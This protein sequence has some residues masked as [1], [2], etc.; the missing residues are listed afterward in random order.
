MLEGAGGVVGRLTTEVLKYSAEMQHRVFVHPSNQKNL[1]L[2]KQSI[3][4]N[5][6][7]LCDKLHVALELRLIESVLTG[8]CD[9]ETLLEAPPAVEKVA[10]SASSD[11]TV[12][13][14]E[15]DAEMDTAVSDRGRKTVQGGGASQKLTSLS[16][17]KSANDTPN[18]TETA[19]PQNSRERV[20][21]ECRPKA[22]SP[23]ILN[24]FRP[25]HEVSGN[26]SVVNSILTSVQKE[27]TAKESLQSGQGSVRGMKRQRREDFQGPSIG[28]EGV[29]KVGEKEAGIIALP[30]GKNG[31]N[32]GW[33]HSHLKSKKEKG[34]PGVREEHTS[35]SAKE[36]GE[37]NVDIVYAK[38]NFEKPS[39]S[40][41]KEF[42]GNGKDVPNF[43][44]FR[45]V[46]LGVGSGNSYAVLVPFANEPYRESDI[47]KD[48]DVH[49]FMRHEKKRKANE[50]AADELFHADRLIRQ[51]ATA[52]V[53]SSNGKTALPLSSRPP[54]GRGRG[55]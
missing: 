25:L 16:V 27:D 40:C 3:P 10:M 21:V 30:A 17:L 49:E 8:T 14:S 4:A 53:P 55:Y 34:L 26:D 44:R 33:T 2:V 39:E 42:V 18:D 19:R 52:Q 5:C 7:A 11:E 51:K 38:I 48:S 36:A 31:M 13:N 9:F 29:D 46:P 37:S 41:R 43:K 12:D 22:K 20:N 54:R 50:A 32:G 15:K 35:G 28:R 45:K 23:A 24:T 6:V 1:K 47:Q